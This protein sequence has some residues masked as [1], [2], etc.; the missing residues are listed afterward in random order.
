[1]IFIAVPGF[2]LLCIWLFLFHATTAGIP[3]GATLDAARNAF[4]ESW[5]AFQ[6][7]VAPAPTLT[8]FVLASCAA[9][10]FAVFLADWAAFRLWS[11]L[12]AIVPASTLFIFCSL[13][14]S[15]Q[16]QIV[17]AVVFSAALLAF[18]LLHRVAR[19]ESAAGWLTADVTRGSRALARRPEIP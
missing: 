12:E 8:G 2:V 17:S 15:D 18:L 16:H 3:T 11:A 6:S 5:D 10:F 1:M 7:V 13:L 14:G 9:V 19:Q 4:N